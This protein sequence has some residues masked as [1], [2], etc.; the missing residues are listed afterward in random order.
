MPTERTEKKNAL[1]SQPRDTGVRRDTGRWR[2]VLIWRERPGRQAATIDV[3]PLVFLS[4]PAI[5]PREARPD[6]RVRGPGVAPVV[7][8]RAWLRLPAIF[9]AFNKDNISPQRRWF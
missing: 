1:S 2:P 3:T 5:G 9:R 6:G 7:A 8:D 4:S